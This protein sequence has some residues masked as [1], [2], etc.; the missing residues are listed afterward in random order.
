MYLPALPA[1]ARS[2]DASP[3]AAQ[4]TV[5]IFFIGLSVGQLLYGPLSDR[6][7]RRWPLLIGMLLYTVGSLGCALAPSTEVLFAFRIVAALGACA[8][9]V[10]VRAVVRD[11]FHT[12]EMLH[13][14]SLLLLVL[15]VSPIFAPLL[16]GWML[17]LAGGWR[18]I[19][20]FQVAAGVVAALA[21]LLWL[22]ES[23]S[24][25]TA[26]HAHLCG[27]FSGRA[28]R[29]VPRCARTVRLGFRPQRRRHHRVRPDQRPPRPSLARRHHPAPGQFRHPRLRPHPA[30]RRPDRLRGPVGRADP[31]VL[32][33]L[34]P[35]LLRRQRRQRGDAGRPPARRGHRRPVGSRLLRR[36]RDLRRPGRP[37]PRRHRRSYGPGDR[38][39]A[40]HRRDQPAG[41]G[42]GAAALGEHRRHIR[43]AHQP[44]RSGLQVVRQRQPADAVAVQGFDVVADGGEHAAH[45]VVAA[46]G[47]GHQGRGRGQHL[48]HRGGQRL[49]V[50]LEQQFAGREALALP[51]CERPGQS[52]Q[53][54]LGDVGAGR[55][56]PVQQRPVVGHQQQARGF[57]VE[58]ADGGDGRLAGPPAP[59]QQVIDQGAGLLVRA[60]HAQRL[61]QHQ[62]HARRRV[63]RP[64]LD[65][66][67][68]GQV[69]GEGQ[70]H[71]ALGQGR[72]VERHLPVL[73]QALHLLARAVAKVGE[74]PV[75]PHGL[76]HLRA[77][78]TL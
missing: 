3:A 43:L 73:D 16:G 9:M 1:L 29:P 55:D 61:V 58:P 57:L 60:G 42:P 7:G 25:E 6:Y 26:A 46:L 27:E 13:I 32:R 75:E 67:A 5:A 40:D 38:G 78:N 33:D 24:A 54:T 35:G 64:A 49:V 2:L 23:R 71:V 62:G 14:N 70:P 36:R 65:R 4:Q 66:H 72:A 21:V 8:G 17:L 76:A 39:L 12:S 48:Q 69:A 37:L 28:D 56:D 52:R 51:A 44:P 45:H 15:G 30:G 53:V 41:A 34:Q 50:A 68:L 63:Q 18:S 11:T 20:Y 10:L 19:F 74:Q 77:S 47:D 31:P 59:G 22:P